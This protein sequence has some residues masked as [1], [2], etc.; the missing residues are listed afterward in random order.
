MSLTE[1][2]PLV[3]DLSEDD[4]LS[5]FKFLAMNLPDAELRAVFPAPEYPVVSLYDSTEAASILMQAIEDDREAS[6]NV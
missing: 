3:Q 4:R 2:I 5:L 1:L 6:E